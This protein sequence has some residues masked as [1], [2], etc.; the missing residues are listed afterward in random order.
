MAKPTATPPS[1][2]IDGVDEDEVSSTDAAAAA[3]QDSGDLARA[4][5]ETKARPEPS[6]DRGNRDDR[7]R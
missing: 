1:S 5:D 7:S 2:D 6:S 4:H 3:G